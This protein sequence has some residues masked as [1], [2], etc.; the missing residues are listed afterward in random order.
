[1]HSCSLIGA[2]ESSS[3]SCTSTEQTFLMSPMCSPLHSNDCLR[4]PDQSR[5]KFNEMTTEQ[6]KAYNTA[7]WWDFGVLAMGAYMIWVAAYYLKVNH[8]GS[9]TLVL[10]LDEP[11]QTGCHVTSLCS[12]SAFKL[13]PCASDLCM[14]A[15]A[16][17]TQLPNSRPVMRLV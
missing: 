2:A 17:A 6:Q 16:A 11:C 4:Y 12:G 10:S 8:S 15:A 14:C 5:L 7:T 9:I 1:M 13:R 3:S